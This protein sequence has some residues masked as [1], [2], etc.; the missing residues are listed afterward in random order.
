MFSTANG[1]TWGAAVHHAGGYHGGSRRAASNVGKIRPSNEGLKGNYGSLSR[2][3]VDIVW[4][5]SYR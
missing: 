2:K 5:G 4:A 3:R 1:P